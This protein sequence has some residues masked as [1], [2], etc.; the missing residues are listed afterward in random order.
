MGVHTLCWAH[1]PATESP[2]R[3]TALLLPCPLRSWSSAGSTVWLIRPDHLVLPAARTALWSLGQEGWM[4]R[5]E[6]AQVQQV[7]RELALRHARST[8]SRRTYRCHISEPLPP[9]AGGSQ[10]WSSAPSAHGGASLREVP[11]LAP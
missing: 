2:T 1:P 3:A 9:S 4:A 11:S 7:Q 8:W 6:K 10:G 5:M